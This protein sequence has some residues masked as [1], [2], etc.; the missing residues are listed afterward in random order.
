MGLLL[1]VVWRW[2][3]ETGVS[4]IL[5]RSDS[6]IRG[7]QGGPGQLTKVSQ[8]QRRRCLVGMK[9]MRGGSRGE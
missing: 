7:S 6:C 1:L 4:G 5:K 8:G 3:K 2:G 9:V